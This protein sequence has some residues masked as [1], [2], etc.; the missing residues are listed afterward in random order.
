[1]SIFIDPREG[2][3]DLITYYPINALNP[4][5]VQLNSG[6]IA[7]CGKGPNSSS[8]MVGIELKS[9]SDL[10]NSINTKRLQGGQ[11]PK[12]ILDYDIRW[13]LVYG[14]IR[15]NPKDGVSLQ[16]YRQGSKLR[17][18]GW[19]TCIGRTKKTKAGVI[20]EPF[21]YSTFMA[22]LCGPS[23]WAVGIQSARVETKAEAAYWIST[24][25]HQWDKRFDKHTSLRSLDTT[26]D[27]SAKIRGE[28]KQAISSGLPHNLDDKFKERLKFANSIPNV[29]YERAFAIA[30]YFPSVRAM[31]QAG[32]EEWATIELRTNGGRKMKLGPVMAKAIVQFFS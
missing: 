11:I 4:S 26:S 25:Y 19:Y 5:L 31:V 20:A 29:G 7:F 12:L 17:R 18:E 13:I 24:L 15:C 21:L 3:K 8:V 10:I 28:M 14:R 22:F 30:S 9:V 6:D 23:L 2:S 16:E 1:M 27:P 32:V